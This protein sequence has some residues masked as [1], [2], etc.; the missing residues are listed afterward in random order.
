M[1]CL[2]TVF[3]WVYAKKVSQFITL[4]CICFKAVG[5]VWRSPLQDLSP[6]SDTET[7]PEDGGKQNRTHVSCNLPFSAND[8][9]APWSVH[10]QTLIH[11]WG[12]VVRQGK[13]RAGDLAY[14]QKKK[15]Q[16]H[17]KLWQQNKPGPSLPLP[18]VTHQL[19]DGGVDR[20]ETYEPLSGKVMLGRELKW[21]LCAG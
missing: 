1:Y 17:K 7:L 8:S 9:R 2:D 5:A 4:C 3:T 18:P 10:T 15:R 6:P 20:T 14:T 19:R 12:N 21:K 16:C 11:K 13:Y